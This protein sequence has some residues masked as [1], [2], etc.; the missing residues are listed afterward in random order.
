MLWA[1][2]FP[3]TLQFLP[4]TCNFDSRQAKTQISVIFKFL[5]NSKRTY[6]GVTA[7]GDGESGEKGAKFKR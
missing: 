2:P 4:S 5:V 3:S 7:D 6:K 1:R